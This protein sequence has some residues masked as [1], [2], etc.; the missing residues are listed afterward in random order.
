MDFPPDA[1]PKPCDWLDRS[2]NIT[3]AVVFRF[4]RGTVPRTARRTDSYLTVD[5]AF[6]ILTAQ[7]FFLQRIGLKVSREKTR[8]C[9]WPWK[10]ISLGRNTCRKKFVALPSTKM[11]QRVLSI[12]IE[13]LLMFSQHCEMS[14]TKCFTKVSLYCQCFIIGL[15]Y[16]VFGR[17]IVVNIS[18]GN[19]VVIFHTKYFTTTVK[20]L[21]TLLPSLLE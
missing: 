20:L 12:W 16:S 21:R 8:L 15:W 14:P 6:N 19:F 5:P 7:Q 13:R 3:P 18:G 17:V 11:F 4:I 2:I 9:L 1:E 10:P